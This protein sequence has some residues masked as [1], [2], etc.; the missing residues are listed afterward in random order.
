MGRERSG[1]GMGAEGGRALGRSDFKL[2]GKGE[3][4]YKGEVSEKWV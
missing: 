2:R 1:K 3:E 4:H